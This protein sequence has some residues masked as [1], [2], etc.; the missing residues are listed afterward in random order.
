MKEINLDNN[1][2]IIPDKNDKIALIDADTMV[3]TSCLNEQYQLD[4]FDED[5]NEL[6]EQGYVVDEKNSVYYGIDI[7]D[8]YKT[9]QSKLENILNKT[10]CISYELHLTGNQRNSFRY[11][12]Y[13]DYKANRKEFIP[14]AGLNELKELLLNADNVFVH[15]E[16]EADDMVVCKKRTNSD[17][18]ILVAVDKDVL[19]AVEGKHFNY[20]ESARYGIQQKWIEITKEH[21]TMWPYYQT[22]IGDKSD[23]IIGPK[24]IGPKRALKFVNEKMIEEEMWNGVVT[25]YASKGLTEMDAIINMNLV[26]MNLLT[27]ENDEYKIV[28]W[29]P[30]FDEN[31]KHVGLKADER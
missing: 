21:A 28:N 17:K 9:F 22:I 2:N 6:R 23:N 30:E 4:I 16:W 1:G 26:N 20:Y 3:Y 8:A 18:Y 5:P 7:Q 29:H 27:Y 11:R 10:G 19:N 31:G 25:A 13:K 15:N 12:F 14:P 24:G